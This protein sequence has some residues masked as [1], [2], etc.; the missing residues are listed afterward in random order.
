MNRLIVSFVLP[1]FI[2]TFGVFSTDSL[3]AS[4]SKN[5][6]SQSFTFTEQHWWD[7]YYTVENMHAAGASAQEIYD[8]TTA[9]MTWLGQSDSAYTPPTHSWPPAP[10]APGGPTP[11]TE[12]YSA[13]SEKP[14]ASIVPMTPQPPFPGCG[15][16]SCPPPGS[17]VIPP[18]DVAYAFNGLGIVI[19]TGGGPFTVVGA[20]FQ[21]IAI[22]IH[23]QN[24]EAEE[25]DE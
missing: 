2:V 13:P 24:D 6:E 8:Y 17:V 1:A 25:E 22:I 20:G 15:A 12:P 4:E 21:I 3:A 18:R 5:M 11:P 7:F 23:R 14:S 19:S 10:G 9:V 16:P